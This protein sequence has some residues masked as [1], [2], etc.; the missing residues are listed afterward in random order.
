MSSS[1]EL[2]CQFFST[3]LA[4][5]GPSQPQQKD[6]TDP[7]IKNIATL[8]FNLAG[9]VSA[10]LS[11]LVL[12]RANTPSPLSSRL[13]TSSQSTSPKNTGRVPQYRK[14]TTWCC[15]CCLYG[16]IEK[17]GPVSTNDCPRNPSHPAAPPN[18]INWLLESTYTRPVHCNQ[19]AITTT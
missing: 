13:S 2:Y 4:P 1:P 12:G 16:D 11:L 18:V 6:D 17:S 3:I 10:C 8:S 5:G 19:S 9:R 14:I 7:K 15:S